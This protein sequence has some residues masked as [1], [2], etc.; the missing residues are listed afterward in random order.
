M[1]GNHAMPRANA[2]KS[3]GFSKVPLPVDWVRLSLARAFRLARGSGRPTV[4]FVDGT[5]ASAIEDP[6]QGQV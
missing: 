4:V 2:S 3:G 6:I 5:D 1:G